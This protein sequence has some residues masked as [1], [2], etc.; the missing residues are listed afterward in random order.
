MAIIITNEMREAAQR[1]AERRNPHIRHHFDVDYMSSEQRDIIGFIGEFACKQLFDIPWQE[2][3][4]ENYIQT[5]SGDIILPGLTIDIKTETIPYDVLMKLVKGKI[6][7]N[8]PYGR[9]LINEEQIGLLKRYDYVVWGA[10]ARGNPTHWYSLG[11]LDTQFIL[12]NYPNPVIYTPFGGQYRTPCLNIRHSELRNINY[13]Y[14]I[15]SE[16]RQPL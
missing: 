9:R 2:D 11:F 16:H 15:I 5:D 1:E 8:Q 3:I 7:D 4:R 6:S 13:M 12:T 14:R 10:V